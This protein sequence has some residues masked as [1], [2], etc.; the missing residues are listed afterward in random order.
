M[1]DEAYDYI[2]THF[3]NSSNSK[4]NELAKLVSKFKHL[5]Y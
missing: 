4:S 3:Q 5:E 2:S 1:D